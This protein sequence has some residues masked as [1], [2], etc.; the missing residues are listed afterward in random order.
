[1]LAQ[2]AVVVLAPVTDPW[3]LSALHRINAMLAQ[4]PNAELTRGAVVNNCLQIVHVVHHKCADPQ[5]L[6]GYE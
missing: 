5:L 6:K 1:M 4:N 2:C 3:H